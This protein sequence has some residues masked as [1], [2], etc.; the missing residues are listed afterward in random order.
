MICLKDK[1]QGLL[2]NILINKYKDNE[3][4]CKNIEEIH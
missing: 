4:D 1:L 3:Y 2:I